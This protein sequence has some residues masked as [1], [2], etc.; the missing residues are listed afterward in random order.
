[1]F[2]GTP[3]FTSPYFRQCLKFYFNVN[4]LTCLY[5]NVYIYISSCYNIY[6]EI[7]YLF[8]FYIGSSL[9]F[10]NMQVAIYVIGVFKKFLFTKYVHLNKC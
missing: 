9:V 3:S 10:T 8:R 6:S 5:F 7:I 4:V 2:N 1:M